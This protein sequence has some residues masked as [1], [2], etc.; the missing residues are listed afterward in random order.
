MYSVVNGV[1]IIIWEF[2]VTVHFAVEEKPEMREV[3]VVRERGF[4][5]REVGR[6]SWSLPSMGMLCVGLKENVIIVNVLIFLSLD[7]RL[8]SLIDPEDAVKVNSVLDSSI[9]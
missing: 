2:E 3:Q 9:L 8:I 5:E 4:I 7:M 6:V 1:D